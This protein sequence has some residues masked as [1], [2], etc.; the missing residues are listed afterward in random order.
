VEPLDELAIALAVC[1]EVI[2]PLDEPIRHERQWHA[3]LQ[4]LPH[5]LVAVS[6]SSCSPLR[7]A[8]FT[9]ERLGEPVMEQRT[10]E[11]AN[12]VP[13]SVVLCRARQLVRSQQ[14]LCDVL[15]EVEVVLS[16]AAETEAVQTRV[17][18]P[19]SLNGQGAHRI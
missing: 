8:L 16:E 4:Q 3:P 12:G 1:V 11:H 9:I 7:A 5:A 14:G 13:V 17:F 18:I 19:S 2:Q 10:R 6:P 15:R